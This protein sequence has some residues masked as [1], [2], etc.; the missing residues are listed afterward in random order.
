LFRF[1]S[2]PVGSTKNNWSCRFAAAY[3]PQSAIN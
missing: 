3:I 1:L 2:L